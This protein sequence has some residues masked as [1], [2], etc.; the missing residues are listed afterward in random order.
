M[1]SP[2]NVWWHTA[3]KQNLIAGIFFFFNLDQYEGS[4]VL[5]TKM[6]TSSLKNIQWDNVYL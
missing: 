4:I 1:K 5:P 2:A 6:Y 3:Q